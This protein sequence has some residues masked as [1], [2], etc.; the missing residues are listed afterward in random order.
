MPGKG[1]RLDMVQALLG[2]FGAWKP[3]GRFHGSTWAGVETSLGILGFLQRCSCAPLCPEGLHALP[4]PSSSH[5]MVALV[6]WCGELWDGVR[7][8]IRS[9]EVSAQPEGGPFQI[10]SI[11]PHASRFKKQRFGVKRSLGQP[12]HSTAHSHH[13]NPARGLAP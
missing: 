7:H 13:S 5:S 2:S 6:H 12:S 3:G 9:D 1:H 10:A 11:P 8:C 4:E